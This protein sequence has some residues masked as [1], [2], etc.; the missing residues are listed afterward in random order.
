MDE[1]E[2]EVEGTEEEAGPD[3]IYEGEEGYEEK[4][5]PPLS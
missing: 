5:E 3:I 2:I 4:A 1:K